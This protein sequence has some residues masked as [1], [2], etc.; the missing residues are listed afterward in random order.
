MMGNTR[1]LDADKRPCC[2][3]NGGDPGGAGVVPHQDA[4]P[5]KP[6]DEGDLRRQVP[7]DGGARPLL[8]HAIQRQ[9]GGTVSQR[10]YR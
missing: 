8:Q 10:P 5:G 2:C 3:R 4:V 7:G 6:G 1:G 9:T